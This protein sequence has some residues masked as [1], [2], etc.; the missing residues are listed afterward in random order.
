MVVIHNNT[1]EVTV[2][3]INF[4]WHIEHEKSSI[5]FFRVAY[6]SS[7]G[8]FTCYIDDPTEMNLEGCQ[9]K[10]YSSTD[11]TITVTPYGAFNMSTGVPGQVQVRT[12]DGETCN[13]AMKPR[14]G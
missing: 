2:D 10:L 13:G 4:Q 5:S 1:V 7:Y 6:Y 8:N 9:V 3:S 14:V 11:Y 12:E